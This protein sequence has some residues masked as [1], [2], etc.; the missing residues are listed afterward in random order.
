MNFLYWNM[1]GKPLDDLVVSLAHE[2][3]LDVIILS[4]SALSLP[5]VLT[6]LNSPVRR[7][8][9]LGYSPVDD[10]MIFMR[11]PRR[12]LKIARD[13][14]GLSVRTLAPPLGPSILV[15]VVHL[16]S[17][18]YYD[19]DDQAQLATRLARDIDAEERKAGHRR[20]L[21]V[22]DLNMNPF[23][24]GVVGCEGL[25]A[26]MARNIAQKGSRTVA[27]Q[28]RAFFYNPMWGHFGDS[29]PGPPGTY[30]YAGSK[31]V[32][33]YWNMFDQIMLR[34]ELLGGFKNDTLEILT[35]AGGQNLLR[36]SGVPDTSIGS[37]HL[38][39]IFTL[40]LLKGLEHEHTEPMGQ[41]S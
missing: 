35:S 21:V 34:P 38:P 28:E 11:L 2:H 40:D 37:D 27:G 19:S 10:P 4:E 26:T 12:C 13:S 1:H 23:E 31:P 20:T 33:Y 14:P 6:T 8:Y 3:D 30:Y 32:T 39:V 9:R 41:S 5:R 18:L 29:S 17:K 22:G 25:N 36:A 15:V 7:K 24:A 16:A